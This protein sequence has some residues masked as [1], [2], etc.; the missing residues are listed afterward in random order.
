MGIGRAPHKASI[1]LHQYEHEYSITLYEDNKVEDLDKLEN[2]ICLDTKMIFCV[3]TIVVYLK[4][5]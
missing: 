4:V 3:L 1:Y 2:S 5:L